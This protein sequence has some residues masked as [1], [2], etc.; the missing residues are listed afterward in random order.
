MKRHL[1][2]VAMLVPTMYDLAEVMTRS[3]YSEE[4]ILDFGISG[5]L[6]FLA[7]VPLVGACRVPVEA[8]S[9]FMAGT[10]EF[11]ATGMPEHWTGSPSGEW[12]IKRDR[13][14]I[15]PDS[16]ESL[17][18]RLLENADDLDRASLPSVRTSEG[19]FTIEQTW[20]SLS[21][22]LE[23]NASSS[24]AI[25]KQFRQ[26]AY[27]GRLSVRDPQTLC[28]CQPSRIR[29]DYDLVTVGDVNAF[30]KKIQAPYLW[31]P[32]NP[33]SNCFIAPFSDKDCADSNAWYDATLDADHWWRLTSVTPYEAAMLHC[34]FNP[35]DDNSSPLTTTTDLTTPDDYKKLL[36][37][38]ED[39]AL[40]TPLTRSLADWLEV[41]K[42]SKLRFHE[43][44]MT[45]ASWVTALGSQ[46]EPDQPAQSKS[47]AS[48]KTIDFAMVATR[49]QLITAFGSFTGMDESWFLN[50]NDKPKL[51]EAR[52]FVGQ[53]GRGHIAEPL[54]CPYQVMRW[55]VT[56][57]RKGTNRK[58]IQEATGWRMLKSHFPK[59]YSQ[60]SLGDPSN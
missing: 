19:Y 33:T 39:L 9:H 46:A 22:Q 34:R 12:T 49:Q 6:V 38:F 11:T 60:F 25:E 56:K 2:G 52:Q 55:L 21:V 7:V 45:Y 36:R 43:W 14:R 40:T 20:Q 30:L 58:P 31:M 5:E 54:F 15:L 8:L 53:G 37:V 59:V 17:S 28:I 24:K 29:E 13:L 32:Q 41:A 16:W 50:L 51:K 4:T 35:H 10:E 26:G 42:T 48:D 3:G 23:L 27:D 47:S 44:I 57:P 18:V 1:E